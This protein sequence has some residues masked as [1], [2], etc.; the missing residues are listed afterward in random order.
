M[1]KNTLIMALT[2]A[3]IGYICSQSQPANCLHFDGFNDNVRR[4]VVSVNNSSVSA[5]IRISLAGALA[6]NQY[7][8][9]N[10]SATTNGFG[11]MIPSGS[12]SVNIIYGGIGVVQTG[13]TLTPNNWTLLS[14]TI[15]SNQVRFFVNGTQTFS[16]TTASAPLAATSGSLSLGSDDLGNQVFS[17]LMEEFRFWNRTI[18]PAAIAHKSNCQ[19]NATEPNL[20]VYYPFN[21]GIA[22]A[23]NPTVT[24]LFDAT[25]NSLNATLFSFTLTG[26]SS[27]WLS[28]NGALTT[29]CGIAPPNATIVPSTSAICNGST[30]SFTA[31]GINTFT[32][33]NGAA[34]ATISPSPSVN[35]TYSVIGFDN[36]SG[37]IYMGT[38]S[39]VVNPTPTVSV[40]ANNT[41]VCPNSSLILTAN[42]AQTYS[43]SNNATTFSTVVNPG[44]ITT[45]SV[46]GTNT[47]GCQR[48]TTIIIAVLPI[49]QL[50]VSATNTFLCKGTSATITASGATSYT[51]SNSTSASSL[52]VNPSA[53]TTYS[54]TGSNSQGCNNSTSIALTVNSNSLTVTASTVIC[55]GST[56][57]LN[58]SGASTYTWNGT[59][60][61][62]SYPVTASASAVY[63]I[64]GKDANNCIL[65]ATTAI[66]VY[67]LP[68][69]STTASRTLICV[70]ETTSLTA[71]GAT[72][73]S[74]SNGSTSS[75]IVVSPSV[76]A[77]Y[78][79][80]VV[81][82]NT[83]NCAATSVKTISV[84]LCTGIKDKNT[85]GLEVKA[86]PN[87]AHGELFIELNSDADVVIFNHLGEKVIV[88]HS[89]RGTSQFD[90][91]Q[92]HNGF[93]FVRVQQSDFY[94]I[95]KLVKE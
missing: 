48:T 47:F 45:Y 86:Y 57:T 42:G 67:T 31:T 51:W 59:F 2:L 36:S 70:N 90:I 30:A 77:I 43:W 62:S 1:K 19:L 82:T 63:S 20:L 9:Y 80:T 46:S 26:L 40:V 72:S 73:Y 7:L 55:Q 94:K 56:F 24:S 5:G 16:A 61:L 32:W 49:P 84:N 60:T 76:N 93:Y 41:L 8:F 58:A 33:S 65:T 17:G 68:I 3:S 29:T 88:W 78:S 38:S 64:A 15:N 6:T 54:L 44:Q 85:E 50:S 11:L 95:I 75:Q 13:F 18:C 22:A 34:T 79:Y 10:G 81:G 39:L 91:S 14:L 12:T 74:W 4:A 83:N 92:L 89:D 21:Q 87:P 71:S 52:V 53:N 28:S 25:A 69:V 27:N 37:C 23:A 35:T 66:G